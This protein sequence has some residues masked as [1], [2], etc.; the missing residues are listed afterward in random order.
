MTEVQK[1]KL[2]KA[3][4]GELDAVILYKKL[5]E[6]VKNPEKAEKFLKVAADEGKHASILRQYTKEE[7]RPKSSK[8]KLVVMLYKILGE[9]RTMKILAKGE[10]GSIDGY[11]LLVKDFPN[12]Q[13]IME[14]EALHAQIALDM[15]Q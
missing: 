8:A 11:A 1:K 13:S 9:K 14:D 5:A 3:Q 15:I 2:I 10:L 12:I 6:T 7:L 4:Q